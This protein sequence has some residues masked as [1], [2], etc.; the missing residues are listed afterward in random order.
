MHRAIQMATLDKT[1]L[2]KLLE[3]QNDLEA[4]HNECDMQTTRARDAEDDAAEA[5]EERDAA[6]RGA[7]FHQEELLRA[8]ERCPRELV[9]HGS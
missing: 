6:L 9:L 5:R 7:V 2:Q 1:V 8:E 4:V 3:V